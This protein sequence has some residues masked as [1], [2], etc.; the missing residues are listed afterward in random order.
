MTV[1]SAVI[2]AIAVMAPQPGDDAG[3]QPAPPAACVRAVEQQQAGRIGE[4]VAA[5]RECIEQVPANAALLTNFG[6]ALVQSGAFDE[7]IEQYRRALALAPGEPLIRRNLALA[8]YKSGRVEEAA[9]E[10]ESLHADGPGSTP[11]ALMLAD[12][13]LQLSRPRE[14]VAILQPLAPAHGSEP[15]FAYLYGLALMKDGQT[16]A[17]QAVIDPLLRDSGSAEAH[18]LIG[19][20]AFTDGDYPRAVESYA[21]AVQ[22]NPRLPMLQ[23]LYGQAL[24]ATG[25]ADGAA[26]AFRAE[27][28]ANPNDFDANLRLGEILLQRRTYTEAR[29]LLEKATRL[30]SS[31]PEPQYDIARLLHETGDPD[32]ARSRLEALTAVAPD[33]GPAYTLLGEVYLKLGREADAE[34]AFAT[35]TRLMPAGTTDTS[36]LLATG[37]V[38]PAFRLARA[39]GSGETALAS[40]HARTPVVLV[41]G[42]VTCPQFRFDAPSFERLRAKY[43]GR[44]AFLLVYVHE[45]H[46]DDSWR[47]TV[48]DRERIAAP[49]PHSID[50]KRDNAQFCLTRLAL[51]LPAVVDGMD[52]AVEVAYHA[53]PSAAYLIDRDGRIAWR[54]RLGE[55]E[56]SLSGLESAIEV[57]AR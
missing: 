39:D 36:D 11:V 2:L 32:G 21:R 1:G 15:G 50:A 55:Q 53:W 10:F 30:R 12:C 4:A 35:A 19:T 6:A 9:R 7:G 28:A 41:F 48:N 17:A 27:L 57:L 51:T 31:A 42:S 45:A 47:S 46:A 37:T 5:Y 13:L 24:L 34:R 3:A 22:I 52:R 40:L 29:P 54:S 8:F 26:G 56:F 38:A 33:Y 16:A 49:V 25:D 44:I 43:A 23:S 20:A 14:A 18:L